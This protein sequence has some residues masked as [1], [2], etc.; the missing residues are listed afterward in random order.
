MHVLMHTNRFSVQ[1]FNSCPENWFVT[2][3]LQTSHSVMEARAK[4][5]WP[6]WLVAFRKLSLMRSNLLPW[7]CYRLQHWARP[8]AA[9]NFLSLLQ[10]EQQSA[11]TC[12][13]H[14]WG[15]KPLV[16][17]IWAASPRLH[18]D[19]PARRPWVDSSHLHIVPCP[20]GKGKTFMCSLRQWRVE[21]LNVIVADLIS[22]SVAIEWN[23]FCY[24]GGKCQKSHDTINRRWLAAHQVC[25]SSFDKINAVC[26]ACKAI[27]REEGSCLHIHLSFCT[28]TSLEK[29]SVQQP[30]KRKTETLPSTLS[31]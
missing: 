29:P 9:C 22:G 27:S 11:H 16:L 18:D 3:I 19:L 10:G 12:L 28:F 24:H 25:T 8:W 21:S 6:P 14:V 20:A 26:H 23:A 7:L 5:P 30:M 2:G 31:P 4:H 13:L 1:K 15:S 17:Q